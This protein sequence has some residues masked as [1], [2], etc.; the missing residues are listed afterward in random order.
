MFVVVCSA[1]GSPGTTT[2]ALALAAAWPA[3]TPVVAVEADPAGGDLGIRLTGRSGA[4]PPSPTVATLA[5]AARDGGEDVVRRH[6]IALNDQLSVVPGYLS[7]NQ[8]RAIATLWQPLG[9]ALRRADVDS[10]VDVGRLGTSSP[11]TPLLNEADAAVVV[12]RADI[13]SLIHARDQIHYLPIRPGTAIIPLVIGRAADSAAD[14]ADVDQVLAAE[15][16]AVEPAAHISWDQAAVR[17]L[18]AGQSPAGRALVRSKLIRSAQV[19][20][21]RLVEHRAA[22]VIGD[23]A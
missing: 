4:L 9:Q 8:G 16:L 7:P 17:A 5:A 15:G 2:T 23:T 18:E 19:V 12:V 1:K 22:S 10:V 6:A 20:A 14:R 3:E 13:A 21:D 11:A